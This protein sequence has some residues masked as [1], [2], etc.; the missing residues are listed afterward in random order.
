MHLSYDQIEKLV[1]RFVQSSFLFL[2]F[3][4]SSL[5]LWSVEEKSSISNTKNIVPPDEGSALFLQ[6]ISVSDKKK[7]DAII[8]RIAENWDESYE[9]FLLE[10]FY[11]SRDPRVRTQLFELF[12]EKTKQS[13]NTDLNAWFQ[14]VSCWCK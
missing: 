6:L 12:M 9:I 3:A 2:L 13:K 1:M 11:F 10:S 7:Q 8:K 14:Y 5:G 4:L